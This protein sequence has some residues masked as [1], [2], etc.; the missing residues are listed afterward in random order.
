MKK[1]GVTRERKEKEDRSMSQAKVSELQFCT[2]CRII[3]NVDIPRF[4]RP[5][6]KGLNN[7][8]RKAK[9]SKISSA[10][11]VSDHQNGNQGE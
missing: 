6:A 1:K 10:A 3:A 7:I 11:K 4:G 2:N 9:T 5:M 8:L